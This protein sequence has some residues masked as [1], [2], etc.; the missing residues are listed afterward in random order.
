MVLY[1]LWTVRIT[2]E[3][4]R[5]RQLGYLLCLTDAIVLVPILVWSIG[6]GM[7]VVLVIP[8]AVRRGRIVARLQSGV[9]KHLARGRLAPDS[10][11]SRSRSRRRRLLSPRGRRLPLERALRVR[12]RV[13]ETEGTRFAVV[14]LRIAGH[15]AMIVDHGKEETRDF[16][17][18]RGAQGFASVG[19]GRPT[20]PTAG[21]THGLCLCDRFSSRLRR[22]PES[23]ARPAKSTPTTSRV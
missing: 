23:E 16:L 15:E 13:L 9:S 7:R 18:R 10:S 20:V 1:S 3:A 17:R 11:G 12:L 2:R 4:R 21:W 19:P 22:S 14:L 6:V 8:V 5:D